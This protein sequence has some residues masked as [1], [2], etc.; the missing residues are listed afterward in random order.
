MRSSHRALGSWI[1]SRVQGPCSRS[2]ERPSV[3]LDAE[4]T[5]SNHGMHPTPTIVALRKTSDVIAAL[6]RASTTDKG[7]QRT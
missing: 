1:G 3:G 4:S 2:R 5:L 6:N 7:G